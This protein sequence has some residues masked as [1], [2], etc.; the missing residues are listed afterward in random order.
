MRDDGTYEQRPIRE[1]ETTATGEPVARWGLGIPPSDFAQP[2]QNFESYWQE[3]VVW[4]LNASISGVVGNLAYD[5]LETAIRRAKDL[6]DRSPLPSP[7]QG[8]VHTTDIEWPVRPSNGLR[9]ELI[10]IAHDTL[11]RFD[12]LLADFSSS[13]LTDVDV[14]LSERGTWKVA[15][16]FVGSDSWIVLEIDLAE[17]AVPSNEN[18]AGGFPVAVWY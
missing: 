2:H 1:Y 5:A 4:L 17:P 9:D 15:F 11:A 14:V 10:T 12:H 8:D 18:S 13:A 3:L 7:Q 6:H 16:R